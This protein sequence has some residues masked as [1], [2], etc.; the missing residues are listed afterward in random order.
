MSETPRPLSSWT[1]FCALLIGK[2][3]TVS[4]CF[5]AMPQKCLTIA[6]WFLVF[7]KEFEE[8]QGSILKVFGLDCQVLWRWFSDLGINQFVLAALLKGYPSN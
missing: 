2:I 5:K 7:V 3:F 1:G 4:V 6:P 8:K